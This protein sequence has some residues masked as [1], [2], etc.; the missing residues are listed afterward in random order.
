MADGTSQDV[1]AWQGPPLP[2][3]GFGTDEHV[4]QP[5]S[6]IVSYIRAPTLVLE[7]MRKPE[8]MSNEGSFAKKGGK[9]AAEKA[10]AVISV[11]RSDV[12]SAGG[13]F[14]GESVFERGC[15]ENAGCLEIV[16][17]SPL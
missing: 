6:T 17:Q 5:G 1:Q 7:A 4:S 15:P 3:R 8:D 10:F 11:R 12:S 14:D 2:Q 9:R 16:D 13:E